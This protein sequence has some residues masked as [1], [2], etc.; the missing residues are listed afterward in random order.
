MF[1]IRFALSLRKIILECKYRKYVMDKKRYADYL[2]ENA[3]I[4]ENIRDVAYSLHKSVNQM[5]DGV[6]PYGFH[7][8]RVAQVVMTIGYEVIEDE[9]D[10]LPV[11]F[12]AYFHDSIED[13]RQTYN[14]IMKIANKLLGNS[15]AFIAAEIVY[16]LTN[17][18]GRTREE[19]AGAKYYEGIRTT[20]YAPFVK[21]CDRL[22]N[23]QYSFETGS[24]MFDIYCKEWEHFKDSITLCPCPNSR[25]RLPS[26]VLTKIDAMMNK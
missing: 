19:R 26:A 14:D 3:A 23:M 13:A 6:L 21:L 15:Q 2:A 1:C 20:P 16:A 24:R 18:K 25:L 4:I 5:Y 22:A 11:I 17:E 9:V 10:I 8:E 7:L 12:G